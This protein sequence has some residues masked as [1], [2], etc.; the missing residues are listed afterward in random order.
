MMKKM[1]T[2]GEYIILIFILIILPSCLSKMTVNK[3]KEVEGITINVGGKEYLLN[4]FP[5][6]MY[7][8]ENKYKKEEIELNFKKNKFNK[9]ID[10][11]GS[12]IYIIAFGGKDVPIFH[13]NLIFPFRKDNKYF[14]IPWDSRRNNEPMYVI[15]D[16]KKPYSG[17]RYEI[18]E[19]INYNYVTVKEMGKT[20][21]GAFHAK[22]VGLGSRDIIEIKGR[23]KV[24]LIYDEREFQ[25][26]EDEV[27]KSWDDVIY[28][29]YEI[30]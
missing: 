12:V 16:F 29:L 13:F 22:L 28:P 10:E 26:Y 25:E 30:K 24:K 21:K 18:N 11:V 5:V 2:I 8:V 1:S 4:I 15:L 23:F 9:R 17:R 20:V 27:E 7:Y 6:G 3:V 19:E 14:A